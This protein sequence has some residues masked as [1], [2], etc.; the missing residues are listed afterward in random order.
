[1]MS[2]PP[3]LQVHF[4]LLPAAGAQLID[5]AQALVV[6]TLGWILILSSVLPAILCRAT[7]SSAAIR[8]VAQ[9][10]RRSDL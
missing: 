9:R 3:I 10:E 7:S 2:P 8:E 1:M 5:A 4:S 6:N